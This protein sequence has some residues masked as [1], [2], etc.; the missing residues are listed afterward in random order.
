[1]EWWGNTSSHGWLVPPVLV[2]VI[3]TLDRLPQSGA[4]LGGGTLQQSLQG[5]FSV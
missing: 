4:V 5:R 3:A 1:M 2:E